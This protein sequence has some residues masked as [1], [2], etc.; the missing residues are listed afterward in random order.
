MLTTASALRARPPRNSPCW[1]PLGTSRD[2]ASSGPADAAEE[3]DAPFSPSAHR[4]RWHRRHAGTI[5]ALET[6]LWRPYGRTRSE[7]TRSTHTSKRG[8][9]P[10]KCS[11]ACDGRVSS[12]DASSHLYV[13]SS[14]STRCPGA[15]AAPGTYAR[16]PAGASRSDP[17]GTH[18]SNWSSQYLC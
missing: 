7:P 4:F 1:L 2:A 16:V 15:S 11:L 17:T 13:S 5:G 18:S 10:R 14:A 3:A 12:T 6:P 9:H 8:A